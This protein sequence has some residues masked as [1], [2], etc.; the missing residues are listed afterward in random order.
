MQSGGRSAGGYDDMKDKE[1]SAR[2]ADSAGAV[3][4]FK[5]L[6]LNLTKNLTKMHQRLTNTEKYAILFRVACPQ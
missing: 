6:N 4:R 2:K 1:G 3:C 5:Q